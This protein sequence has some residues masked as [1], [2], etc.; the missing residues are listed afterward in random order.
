MGQIF[1]HIKALVVLLGHIRDDRMPRAYR[2]NEGNHS[3][4]SCTK[5]QV[6]VVFVWSGGGVQTHKPTYLWAKNHTLSRGFLKPQQNK[7]SKD[8]Q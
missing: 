3:M 7:H 4:S 1:K 8:E 6:S 5:I 2:K